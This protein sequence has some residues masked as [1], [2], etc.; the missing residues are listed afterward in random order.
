MEWEGAEGKEGDGGGA[1]EYEL[2]YDPLLSLSLSLMI[3][4]SLP[5]SNPLVTKSPFLCKTRL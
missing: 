4:H 1:E 2:S 5:P 3:S